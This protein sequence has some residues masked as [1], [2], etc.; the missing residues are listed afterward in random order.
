VHLDLSANRIRRAQLLR[1][2]QLQCNARR[3]VDLI[4]FGLLICAGRSVPPLLQ[5]LPG[6]HTLILDNNLLSERSA[7]VA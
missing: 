5:L 1:P 7:A 2:F 6:L 4:R 3:L